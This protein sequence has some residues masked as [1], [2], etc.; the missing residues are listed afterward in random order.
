MARGRCFSNKGEE[1]G[2][3][4]KLRLEISPGKPRGKICGVQSNNKAG[5]GVRKNGKVLQP[6]ARKAGLAG[7]GERKFRK[8]GRGGKRF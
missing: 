8:N 3:R 2:L 6:E 5:R 7:S 4:K 1:L